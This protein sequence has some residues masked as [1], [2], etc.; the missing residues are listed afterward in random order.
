MFPVNYPNRKYFFLIPFTIASKRTTILSN[1]FNQGGKRLVPWKLED[2]A[3][4]K[5]NLN[6]WKD[7]PCL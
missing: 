1:K 6:K 3:E 5:D 7:F 2:I 4:I